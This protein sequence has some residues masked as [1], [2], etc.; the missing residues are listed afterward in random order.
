M[1]FCVAVIPA[2]YNEIAVYE[3]HSS[4][5]DNFDDNENIDQAKFTIQKYNSIRI[6][7][8]IQSAVMA[9]LP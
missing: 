9:M 8:K 3:F 4:V 1:I 2:N 7:A 6:D 5:G